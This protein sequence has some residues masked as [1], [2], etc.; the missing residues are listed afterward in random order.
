MRHQLSWLCVAALLA[1]AQAW[2]GVTG[3]IT[4][5]VKDGRGQPLP[6]VNVVVAGQSRGAATDMDGEYAILNVAPGTYSLLFSS[7][8]YA[9]LQVD[10]VGVSVDLTTRQDATLQESMVQGETVTIVAERALVQVDQT[11]SASYVDANQLKSMPVTELSQVVSLQA[12]VVDGHFR[13]G[14]SGEVLYLVDGIPVTDAY[15]GS[16]GVDVQVSMVQELQVLS[17]TF[18]AE[19]G[20]AMSGVVNT[21]T[22][23]AGDAP[24]LTVS[25]WLGDYVSGHDTQFHNIDEVDPLNLSNLEL[26]FSSPTPLPW[27]SVN[28]SLRYSDNNG[29]LQG[30]R[31]FSPQESIGAWEVDGTPYRFF[32]ADEVMGF[33]QM[34]LFGERFFLIDAASDSAFTATVQA[35]HFPME[36]AED[37][38]AVLRV[39]DWADERSRALYES[40]SGDGESVPMDV[41]VKRSAQLKLRADLGPGSVLRAL[42]LA[43]DRDYKEYS[44]SR[45]YTPDGRLR[46]TSRNQLVSLKWDKVLTPEMFMDLALSHSLNTYRHRLYEDIMDPRYRSD[47]WFPAESGFYFYSF[48]GIDPYDPNTDDDLYVGFAQMGGTEN[49]HFERRT[50]TWSLK[51]NISRQWGKRH[52]WKSGFD[53]RNHRLLYDQRSVS[54]NGDQ[55]VAPLGANDNYYVRYPW[56]ASAYLQDKIEFSDVTVNAG[57]RLDVFD[58]NHDLPADLREPGNATLGR[59]DVGAKWQLSPRLA[60]AYVVSESGVLH[61]SYGHFFQRPAFDVLYQNPD[62]ELTGLNTVVGNPDL[63][64]EK[65]VQYEIGLQQQLGEDVAAELSFYSRDIRDLVSTDLQIETVNVDKYY[66]YT[67]RD[68]GNIKGFV[69]SLDKRYRGGFHAGLDYTFQVA[70]ANASSADAARNAVEAGKEVNKYLIPL[71][72]DRRHTLNGYL[73][74]DRGGIWGLSLLGS[75]GSG[76]PYTPTP[77]SEDLVVGLL[78]NSG[79]KPVYVNFDL[80]GYWNLLKKPDLQVNF[81]VKNLLDR[82]NENNVFARTGRAGYDIDWQ[83]TQADLAVDPG[84]YSRPREVIVG[85]R[86]SL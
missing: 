86:L 57:V 49:E 76:L 67:N 24:E 19:Y 59:E 55:I 4:G 52:L 14:R 53:L 44:H 23:D 29:W 39:L 33:S 56:E 1:L 17:G 10:Q 48:D 12:G 46:R 2:A 41:E 7:V 36:D 64:V 54:F 85:F 32:R 83:D 73:S 9:A 15:D 37:S 25:G 31:L 27:L 70:E 8:G 50:D 82:L 18:N 77:K 81:Q 42:L 69:L 72:W 45:R 16:R 40:A 3:K 68:F 71:N 6:G 75:Y 13:G 22:K 80:S 11:Y 5:T 34:E 26:G 78:E 61:F 30:Q 51:G 65:T 58:V 43:G 35:G 79:R 60:I 74:V 63:D 84:N 66:M 47:E 21:V 62:F 20:Q 28:G 38:L